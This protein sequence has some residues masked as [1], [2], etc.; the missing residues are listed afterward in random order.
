M[1]QDFPEKLRKIRVN[2]NFSQEHVADEIG[3]SVSS[4]A[5]YEG[6]KV[7]IDFNSVVK[8]AKLYKI[9]L[10]ELMHY[11]EPGFKIAESSAE[12]KKRDRV[13]VVVELD[14]LK[15]TLEEWVKKLTAINQVI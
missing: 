1:K 8:L 4:Y 9:T 2:K 15:E 13:S 10:D 11:G 5:R 12:Y 14:G 6:G 7:Q 3:V